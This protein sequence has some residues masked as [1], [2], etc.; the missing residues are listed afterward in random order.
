MQGLGKR[1]LTVLAFLLGL[2][3]ILLWTSHVVR[4]KDNS[5]EAG[6]HYV[7]A[8]SYLG[9]AEDSVDVFFIGD[10]LVYS[11]ITPM[12]MWGS[13][14][15]AAYDCATGGQSIDL[16][17]TYLTRI[18]ETQHPKVVVIEGLTV[19][20][21]MKADDCV[22]QE[23]ARIFPVLENHGYWKQMQWSDLT[24]EPCYTYI[25]LEKGFYANFKVRKYKLPKDYMQDKGEQ[26]SLGVLK[27]IYLDRIVELCR[28]NDIQLMFLSVPC[29]MY[30]TWARHC[31]LESYAMEHGSLYL[32][33]NLC[34]EELG[35]DP[36]CDFR[37]RGDHLN[38]ADAKK[39]APYIAAFLKQ[40]YGLTDHRGE[41]AYERWAEDWTAYQR[42][43]A[44]R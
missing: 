20:Q 22:Y 27:G 29:P 10:S 11:C 43:Y 37:D 8:N 3:A 40:Q 17:Y 25:E 26:V 33:L 15:L 1:L 16:T 19:M 35:I 24:T 7:R 30:W 6:M 39:I 32:D 34:L 23:A 5:E 21:K 38:Y 31:A 9:E 42:K 13:E 36:S 18:L 41:A 14:G 28:R 2:G 12:E 4:P 44:D